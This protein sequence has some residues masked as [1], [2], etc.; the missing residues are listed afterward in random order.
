MPGTI[1]HGHTNHETAYVVDDYPYGRTL[2]CKI[3]YWIETAEKGANKGKQRVVSQT[4][5]PKYSNE[6]WNKE[7]K[8]TYSELAILYLDDETGHVKW[9]GCSLWEA[10][11]FLERWGDQLTEDQI[12]LL[13]AIDMIAEKINPAYAA[14]T[15]L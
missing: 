3:R 10:K 4:T 8:S 11:D 6:T 13:S 5:N 12:K 2:R 9:D 1:L 15:G 7:K 14:K